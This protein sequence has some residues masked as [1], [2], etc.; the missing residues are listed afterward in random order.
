MGPL[1]QPEEWMKLSRPFELHWIEECID[2]WHLLEP[3]SIPSLL[4]L[5]QEFP[6][7]SHKA[8]SVNHLPIRTINNKCKWSLYQMMHWYSEKEKSRNP[9][10]NSDE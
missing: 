9:V 2:H 5:D 3:D 6:S 8:L 1:N 10:Y 4:A 7:L